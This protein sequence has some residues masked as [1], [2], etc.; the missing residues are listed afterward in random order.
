MELVVRRQVEF[1]Q[2]GV[3]DVELDLVGAE[4]E[5]DDQGGQTD[6]NDDGED[7][8]EQQAEEAA[9]AAAVAAA[10]GAVGGFGRPRRGRNG[11]TVVGPVQM[12]SL[13]HI[14]INGNRASQNQK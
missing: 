7:Q 5:P 13:R 4:D 3:G 1:R 11:R 6:G 12:C 14:I 2:R 10:A 8:L 9:A